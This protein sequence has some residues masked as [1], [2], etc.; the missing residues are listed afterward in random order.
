[1]R[2][3]IDKYVPFT[4]GKLPPEVE[5]AY[6]E[7]EEFTPRRVRDADALIVRTRTRCNAALL[8]GSRVR[9]IATATIGFDHI[10]RDYCAAQGIRWTNA[11]GCNAGAVCDY[12]EEVL[13]RVVPTCFP[14]PATQLTLGVVGVGHVGSLVAAMARRLGYRVL[15]NDPPLGIGV[16]LHE[17]AAQCDI[18]TFHTPLVRNG[19]Y[20]T[21]HLCDEGFLQA[22]RPGALI[23]NA[24]RGGIVDEQALVRSG[25]PCVIDTWEGEPHINRELLDYALLATFHIAGYSMQGKIN[26]TAHC[27]GEL[28]RYFHLPV[29]DDCHMDTAASHRTGPGDAAPGWM[30]RIS[31]SLKQHPEQFE[32][33]RETYPLR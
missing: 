32:H 21:Y 18:I 5:V 4:R 30:E 28:C 26:A 10:D 25:H 24:A 31:A 3:L 8:D 14:Q 16:S 19:Q 27:L 13:L 15:R 1:M 6:L 22:C 29:P 17:I 20:P 7:P 33:L 23:I 12:V 2:V 9:F 11:P